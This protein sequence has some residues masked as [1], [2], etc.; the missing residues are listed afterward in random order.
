MK[1]KKIEQDFFSF[2][3]PKMLQ[4]EEK[5]CANFLQ[6]TSPRHFQNH[7][8]LLPTY[9]LDNFSVQFFLTFRLAFIPL[10]MFC[11]IPTDDGHKIL[12]KSDADFILIMSLFSLSNGKSY[13]FY[14]CSLF[15]TMSFVLNLK[16]SRETLPY[17]MYKKS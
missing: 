12:F 16:F 7:P 8:Y 4:N 2:N 15:R 10:F 5:S 14:I 1:F 6:I 13:D 3:M 17:F 9:N 11:N